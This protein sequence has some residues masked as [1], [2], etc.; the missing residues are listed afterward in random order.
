MLKDLIYDKEADV[1]VYTGKVFT[2]SERIIRMKDREA[3]YKN[4][5]EWKDLISLIVFQKHNDWE[6]M[7]ATNERFAE[8]VEKLHSKVL[9]GRR[10]DKDG[11]GVKSLFNELAS[12]AELQDQTKE[13]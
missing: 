12:I 3:D 1:W 6:E 9:Y 13:K 10:Y 11:L 2:M 7:I 8:V 4:H 5:Q